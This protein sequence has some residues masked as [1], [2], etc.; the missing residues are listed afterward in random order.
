[1]NGRITFFFL[2]L[3]KIVF[4]GFRVVSAAVNHRPASFAM[5]V[6]YRSFSRLLFLLWMLMASVV[7]E[8]TEH[9]IY[10]FTNTVGAGNFSYFKLHKEGFIILHLTTTTGDADLYVSSTTMSPDFMNYNRKSATCG[11]DSVEIP[12][13]MPRPVGIGVYGHPAY[14]ESE[15]V[16]SVYSDELVGSDG[17]QS[18]SQ[19][20]DEEE[21][22]L[23]KIFLGILKILV[24]IVL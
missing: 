2:T 20:V 12:V 15:F 24:D 3:K 21:S 16:L 14:E 1:L 7:T 5:A 19:R 6:R 22:I 4:A 9:L 17:I 13:K 23:W 10:S 8:C 11:F 18:S